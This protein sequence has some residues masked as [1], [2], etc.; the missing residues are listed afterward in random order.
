MPDPAPHPDILCQMDENTDT[1]EKCNRKRRSENSIMYPPG[2]SP[3]AEENIYQDRKKLNYSF[4]RSFFALMEMAVS[5]FLLYR[6]VKKGKLY[7]KAKNWYPFREGMGDGASASNWP[8]R[9]KRQSK[10]SV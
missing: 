3:C 8:S 1:N 5:F 7:G 2:H 10:S 9:W 4:L 6:K